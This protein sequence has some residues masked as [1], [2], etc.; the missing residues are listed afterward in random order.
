MLE[1]G[2]SHKIS[3]FFVKFLTCLLHIVSQA[4]HVFYLKRQR[5]YFLLEIGETDMKLQLGMGQ[6][7]KYV[8]R[9]V[10]SAKPCR[11]RDSTF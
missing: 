4:K 10:A 8:H 2:Y 6:Y 3:V 1:F 5:T 11:F 9:E 7:E